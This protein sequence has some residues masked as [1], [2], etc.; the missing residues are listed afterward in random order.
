GV[1]CGPVARI[2]ERTLLVEDLEQAF[3]LHATNPAFAYVTPQGDIVR[4]DGS[5]TGGD[6]RALPHWLLQRRAEKEEITRRMSDTAVALDETE[7]SF[8]RLREDQDEVQQ[9]L[10]VAALA[11]Q[12]EARL[13]F[14]RGFELQHGPAEAERVARA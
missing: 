2:L 1:P 8:V 5:A 4:L 12:D 10:R 6:G 13:A 3:R 9:R 7:G 11:V 14:E